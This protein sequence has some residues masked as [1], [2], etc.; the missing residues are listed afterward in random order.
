MAFIETPRFPDDISYGSTG[1]P[2]WATDVLILRSGFESRNSNWAQARYS[3][4]AAMGVRD[5]T[6]LD[7]LISWFNAAQGMAHSFRFRDWT[8][9]LSSVLGIPITDTDQQIGIGDGAEVDFQLTKE[10]IQGSLTRS[11]EIK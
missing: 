2:T 5:Q 9:Y 3:F 11:R 4:N 8:D 7:D 6:Q 1:G 10:Y